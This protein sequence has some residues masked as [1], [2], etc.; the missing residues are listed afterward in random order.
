MLSV[1]GGIGSGGVPFGAAIGNCASEAMPE[2]KRSSFFGCFPC[3]CPEPVL[4]KSSFSFINGAKRRFY[5]PH[6]PSGGTFLAISIYPCY[7]IVTQ[8]VRP[9][10]L[11]LSV[12]YGCPEPV[13]FFDPKQVVFLLRAVNRLT[14]AR[15]VS[16]FLTWFPQVVPHEF[17]T[18]YVLSVK[19]TTVTP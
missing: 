14:E 4:V 10:P 18:M 1:R 6:W 5:S 13:F 11:C 16:T 15:G 7:P 17:F 3:V 19:P 8:C 2:D 12:S 9:T